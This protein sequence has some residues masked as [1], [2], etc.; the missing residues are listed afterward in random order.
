MNQ[1]DLGVIRISKAPDDPEEKKKWAKQMA[2]IQISMFV[3]DGWTCNECN[4]K[5]KSVDDFRERN[6][7]KGYDE[8]VVCGVCWPEYVKKNEGRKK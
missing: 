1:K 4:H 8:D 2:D 3:Q 7:K 5:Y 6:P